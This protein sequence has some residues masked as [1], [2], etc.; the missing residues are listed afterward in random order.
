M[1]GRGRKPIPKSQK[2]ISKELQT[3]YELANLGNPNNAGQP[4]RGDKLSFRGDNTKPLS[5]GI[6]DIDSSVKYYM[7]NIIKPFVI[8]NGDR[9]EVPII[10]GN[11]EK[12]SAMQKGGFYR[13]KN[14]KI[15]APLITFKRTS[16]EKNKTIGNKLDANQPHLYQTLTKKFTSKNAYSSFDILN[17]RVP[18]KENYAVV[19]PDY[20][21]VSY[22]CTIFTYYVEQMNK[23]IE[24]MNYAS[25]SY[26]GEPDKFKFK[27]NISSFN[28]TVELND[29]SDRAVKTSFDVK[30][31]GY[32]IP[33]II[34]KDTTAIKK[35]NSKGQVIVI[36]EI[37]GS[38]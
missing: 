33:D 17:N 3:P 31:N 38:K 23:I 27:A 18:I 25:D 10:Y 2:E 16:I 15:M 29:G 4:N 20:V 19:I 5:I 24:A 11:P 14:G 36:K 34:Q 32:I 12:W 9:I 26:W 35:Y 7:E 37:T 22:T 13:D 8:Q 21:N 1:A 30:L 28:T 6:I